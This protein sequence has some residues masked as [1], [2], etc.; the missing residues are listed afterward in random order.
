MLYS[1]HFLRFIAATGV[2][3]HHSGA[4]APWNIVVGSAGVDL[5]FVISGVVIGLSTR[6]EMSIRDFLVR[7][8][9]RIFP[10][11]WL[12]TLV[13]VAY[14]ARFGAAPNAKDFMRSVLL[15]PVLSEAWLPTYFPAWT[16]EFEVFFYFVFACCMLAGCFARPLCCVVLVAVALGFS[17]PGN[18]QV[19]FDLAM[20]LLEF[21]A[22]ILVALEVARGWVPGRALGALLIGVA[23]IW[24][25]AN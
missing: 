16:L 3:V 4:L 15:L 11:Y 7:R 6:R 17:E 1:I 13:W 8:F 23:V 12:A 25:A 24:F 10:L 18:P 21:V 14:A 9:I 5:F 20:M 22:G 19:V 2:V